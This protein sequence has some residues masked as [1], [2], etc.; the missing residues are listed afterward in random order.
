[1]SETTIAAKAGDLIR[2]RLNGQ[3]EV[4]KPVTLYPN[5]SWDLIAKGPGWTR[6]DGSSVNPVPGVEC[7][8]FNGA[9][10]APVLSSEHWHW[11]S[12]QFYRV[13]KPAKPRIGSTV[14]VELTYT[15]TTSA[16]HHQVTLP[17]GTLGV[18]RV[19]AD[20]VWSP[21]PPPPWEPEI[22]KCASWRN[23]E[24]I[25]MIVIVMCVDGPDAWVKLPN[26]HNRTVF[27]CD[28]SPPKGGEA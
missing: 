6:H 23:S 21:P 4:A 26:N 17:D 7:E 19:E 5:H 27:V 24:G 13:T 14:T 12:I 20:L 3:I 1:M 22:G 10:V 16:G 28:L 11:P 9:V 25:S 8:A 2:F 18:V 15:G